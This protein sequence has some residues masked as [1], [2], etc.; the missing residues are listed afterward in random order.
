MNFDHKKRKLSKD[1]GGVSEVIGNI[2][3]LMITVILFTSIIA[4]VN[5]MPMPEQETKASFVADLVF[6]NQ[7]EKADL[8]LRHA[9]GAV[10]NAVDTMILVRIDGVMDAYSLGND[11]GLNNATKWNTGGVWHK[12]LEGTHYSSVIV[13]TVMDMLKKNQIWSSQVTGGMGDNPPA[14]LQRW[15][16]SDPNTPSADPVRDGDDF[17]FYA[18]ITDIDGD[19]ARSKVYI[20]A[21]EFPLSSNKWFPAPADI[22]GDVFCWRFDYIN[23]SGIHAGQLDGG[24]ILVHAEDV[25]GHVSESIFTMVVTKLPYDLIEGPSNKWEALDLEGLDTKLTDSSGS[26]GCAYGFFGENKSTGMVNMDDI[27]NQLDG[28]P[29]VYMKDEKIFIEVAHKY[30]PNAIAMNSLTIKNS[31]TG[32]IYAPNFTNMSNAAQ[33][34][35]IVRATGTTYYECQ[36]NTSSLPP[37]TYLLNITLTSSIAS[38]PSITFYA[39]PSIMVKQS[40]STINFFPQLRF[41]KNSTYLTPWGDKLH[42]FNVSQGGYMVYGAIKVMNTQDS[43]YPTAD[44]IRISDM[45]GGSEVYGKPQS[46]TMIP[47]PISKLNDTWYKFRIDLRYNN[48]N[49]WLSGSTS[50]C[51]G[52]TGFADANEGVYSVTKQVFIKAITGKSDFFVGEDGI[53]VGHANFDTKGYVTYIENNN[54]FTMQTLYQY[55]NTPSDRTTYTSTAMAFA[56][57]TGDGATDILLAQDTSYQLLYFKNSMNTLGGFQAPSSIT[58]PDPTVGIRWIATGDV[59]GDKAIDFAYVS[60]ANKVVIYNNTYGVKAWVYHDY[61]ATV[62]KKILLRDMTGDG[63]A[64]LITLAGGRVY[65]QD[66][67]KWSAVRTDP[68]VA[69]IPDP[70]TTLSGITDFDVADMNAD[71]MLDILTVGTGGDASVNGVWCNNYTMNPAPKVTHLNG[72]SI[73]AGSLTGDLSSV[74]TPGD[75]SAIQIQENLSS[76]SPPTDRV[77]L[78]FQFDTLDSADKSQVLSVVARLAPPT[79]G[80]PTEEVFYAWYSVDTDLR[81]ANFIPMFVI[82]NK[83][84]YVN[85]TFR[86]PSM[87]AGKQ[88]FIRFTDSSI[89]T[90]YPSGG[91]ILDCL[92]LDYISVLAD[93]YGRYYSQTAVSYRYQVVTNAPIVYTCVRAG[94]I[95][96]H[97]GHLDVVVAKNGQWV[98]YDYKTAIPGFIWTNTSFYVQSTNVLMANTAPTLFDVA[99]VNGDGLSDIVTCHKTLIQNTISELG[100]FMNLHPDKIFYRVSELGRTDG[101]GS[102]TIARAV[103]LL[104]S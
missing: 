87:A 40:N 5:S 36:I 71:G 33:P 70:P 88:L 73:N 89:Q 30:M 44:D 47:D 84:S 20:D 69:W 91:E 104:G 9:G 85:Y 99:D 24:H 39:K 37:G 41:F 13:V 21:H 61:G 19:L 82:S 56:D 25:A 22:N 2:L 66:L 92:D 12:Q 14:I 67:S 98:A 58:R 42:P 68:I 51:L 18:T 34:F 31:L 46:G 50:Y 60:M 100:Y 15:T 76:A 93:T 65:V 27:R 74:R 45:A 95:A 10:L 97:S 63:K 101:S 48:G 103:N 102:I 11:T 54:F 81:T 8:S 16:D 17:V 55:T 59:N 79:Q 52:V 4:F 80:G 75:N 26:Q 32:R 35:Y 86:L 53:A 6:T 96:G 38:G 57:L 3:I 78:T 83:D 49:Q 62:V 29:A 94:N 64:D 7:G 28:S 90:S 23:S 43:P 1:K 77:N 72:M